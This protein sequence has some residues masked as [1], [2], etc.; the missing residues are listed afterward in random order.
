V[1]GPSSNK[2]LPTEAHERPEENKRLVLDDSR[3]DGVAFTLLYGF[4]SSIRQEPVAIPAALESGK[5]DI[6]AP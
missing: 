5:F 4:N 2:G 1:S 3:R 6:T